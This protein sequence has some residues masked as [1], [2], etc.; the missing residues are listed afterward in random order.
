MGTRR[1]KEREIEAKLRRNVLLECTAPPRVPVL[2][3]KLTDSWIRPDTG[4]HSGSCTFT[5]SHSVT[6][7]TVRTMRDMRVPRVWR[8]VCAE[9]YWSA[10][11][12]VDTG[13]PRRIHHIVASARMRRALAFVP[14]S[15]FTLFVCAPSPLHRE[16]TLARPWWHAAFLRLSSPFQWKNLGGGKREKGH[17]DRVNGLPRNGDKFAIQRPCAARQGKC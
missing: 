12:R 14:S 13:L 16:G 9:V 3:A 7:V 2:Q 17:V 15:R 6:R 1:E 8:G 11:G 5:R 4:V 10:D